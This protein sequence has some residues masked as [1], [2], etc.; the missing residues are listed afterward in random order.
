MKKLRTKKL[1]STSLNQIPENISTEIFPPRE[2]SLIQTQPE[3]KSISTSSDDNEDAF[4]KPIQ[5]KVVN[6]P[7]THHLDSGVVNKTQLTVQHK[8]N[9]S[10]NFV[11]FR[12][13][14][15]SEIGNMGNTTYAYGSTFVPQGKFYN[16]PKVYHSKAA[17][18]LPLKSSLKK[19]Q[20]QENIDIIKQAKD[21]LSKVE[22]V[23]GFHKDDP[24]DVK[25]LMNNLKNSQPLACSQ[26]IQ[27]VG[28]HF[29]A[30]DHKIS[31]N[32]KPQLQKS[33]TF[34]NFEQFDTASPIPGQLEDHNPPPMH[35][36]DEVITEKYDKA[37]RH[38]EFSREKYGANYHDR[39]HQPTGNRGGQ[40]YRDQIFKSGS[41]TVF[42]S[43]VAEDSAQVVKVKGKFSGFESINQRNFYEFKK[44]EDQKNH[45]LSANQDKQFRIKSQDKNL[46]FTPTMKFDYINPKV[47]YG[48][49]V[50]N[51]TQLFELEHHE[52]DLFILR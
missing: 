25:F 11:R 17:A 23:S 30:S 26:E 19:T 7:T 35:A 1:S 2:E 38:L 29:V 42:R 32:Q 13:S 12:N 9:S 24:N 31:Q 3:D 6:H 51:N 39:Y 37:Y 50:N 16:Q 46:Y 36:V 52:F 21:K 4:P 5:I 14:S 10:V 18:S 8:P 34:T 40:H 43:S 33:E 47:R 27:K 20:N 15:T 44:N 49:K 22:K 45:P 41:E 28:P 48:E